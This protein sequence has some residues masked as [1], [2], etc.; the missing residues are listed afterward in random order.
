MIWAFPVLFA[1]AFVPQAMISLLEDIEEMATLLTS[2]LLSHDVHT[3]RS[4]IFLLL[5]RAAIH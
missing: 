2:C 5:T 4:P 3:T 1:I